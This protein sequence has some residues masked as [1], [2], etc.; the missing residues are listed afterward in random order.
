MMKSRT[1]R[2]GLLLLS[3]ALGALLAASAQSSSRASAPDHTQQIEGLQ[4]QFLAATDPALRNHLLAELKSAGRHPA[5]AAA[6]N[7]A[8]SAMLPAAS[9]IDQAEQL[10]AI[11][12]ANPDG[13]TAGAA[14]LSEDQEFLVDARQAAQAAPQPQGDVEALADIRIDRLRKDSLGNDGLAQSHVQQLWRIN[15][16]QGA[17]AFASHP[18]MYAAMSERLCLLRARVLQPGGG[19]VPAQLSADQPVVDRSVSMYFDSRTRDLRFPSLQPG[20]LVEIDYRLLPASGVNPWAG[21]YAHLDLFTDTFTTRLRRRV[22]VAPSTLQLYAVEHG[23]APAAVRSQDGE[24]TRI[25]EMRD[26]APTPTEA[27]SPGASSL[28]PYLHVST[29]GSMEQ[30]GRWYAAL[31]QPALELDANLRDLARQIRNRNLTTQAKVQAVYESV[32]R[33][34]GYAA[35]EFGVH[36]YQPYPLATVDQRG[37]GDCKDQAAMIV[38]LLRAVGVPAEFAMVRTRSAGEIAPDA[39]SVQLFNHAAAYVPE[40]DLFLDGTVEY[41]AP[42]ELPPDD[43]GAIAFTVDAGGKVTRRIVPFTSPEASRVFRQVQARLSTDGRLKFVSQ[44]RYAGYFAA[45]ERRTSQ[46]DDLAGTSQAAL[47]RFYPTVRVAH[48]VAEGTARAS[49]EVELKVEGEI[50][51][52]TWSPKLMAPEAAVHEAAVHEAAVPEAAMHEAEYHEA[53]YQPAAAHELKL[54]SSLH[55]AALTAKYAG[56]PT[57]QNPLLLPATP[58]ER[59]VFDYELPAGAQASL[60]AD[61]RLQT[62]FGRVEVSY[63]LND[64]SLSPGKLRVETYTELAPLTINPPDYAAFRAFCEAADQ[65]LRREVTIVL[66]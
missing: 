34:T 26:I 62:P 15:T 39:Y 32:Q 52:D 4:R 14:N 54:H 60:P 66:P 63:R 30:F 57:R 43:L 41:A 42:G 47:A 27:M 16:A 61:T 58:S 10:L 51:V 45:V 22:L 1:L 65:A 31:L 28:G 56:Q 33:N 21:Y 6:L 24:T 23:L 20:D 7:A 9:S 46:S 49:R 11:A 18:L 50:D 48:A 64:G 17:K 40:L 25:W 29:I 36:S 55:T 19:E 13:D 59:E 3:F 12:A 35:F 37:F 44:T 2:T 38:A 53:A 5:D 8:V